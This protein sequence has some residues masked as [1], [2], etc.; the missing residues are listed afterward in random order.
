MNFFAFL[1]WVCVVVQ[2]Y[3]GFGTA[4]RL[5]KAGGDN[6]LALFGWLFLTNLASL[7]PG[8]GFWLWHKYRRHNSESAVSKLY[9]TTQQHE[10][11]HR[12]Y[13]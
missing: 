9:E 10:P 6:G 2:N 3:L 11:S 1:W 5:T 7:V 12:D 4:Y 13:R 8:L